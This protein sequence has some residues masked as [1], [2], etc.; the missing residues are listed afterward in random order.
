MGVVDLLGPAVDP[1]YSKLEIEVEADVDHE[2]HFSLEELLREIFQFILSILNPLQPLRL[3]EVRSQG[4]DDHGG[5]E[6]HI[7]GEFGG[8]EDSCA[9][10]HVS[11]E[12]VE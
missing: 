11:I 1:K 12:I 6:L 10:V 7:F 4:F 5:I 8:D 3:P 2:V 9:G